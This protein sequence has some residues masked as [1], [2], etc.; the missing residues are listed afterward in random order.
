MGEKRENMPRNSYI[1]LISDIFFLKNLSTFEHFN[2]FY[3]H[4]YNKYSIS[5]Y[6]YI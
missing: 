6:S 5:P 2:F 3:V 1:A 4:S